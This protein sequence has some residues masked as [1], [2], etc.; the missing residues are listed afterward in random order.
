MVAFKPYCPQCA[1]VAPDEMIGFTCIPCGNQ[2]HASRLVIS[3]QDRQDRI[4]RWKEFFRESNAT[5]AEIDRIPSWRNLNHVP[6][7]ALI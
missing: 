3:E 4:R 1:G 5:K 7:G 6:N 2:G